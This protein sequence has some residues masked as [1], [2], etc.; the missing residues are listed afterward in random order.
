MVENEAK[1]K[2]KAEK[3]MAHIYE[4]SIAHFEEGQ[5]VKGKIV[6]LTPKEVIVDIGYKSEGI[7][8]MNEFR[9]PKDLKVGEEIDVL[10]EAKE[11]LTL[12]V[13]AGSIT[14][15]KDGKILIRGKDLV[16]RADR[17]NRIKGG[18][19]SIN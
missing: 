17:M 11:N 12:R 14:L 4:S 8:S 15:R 10:L 13:G 3:G 19:V 9:S 1:E 7:I 6:G 16:S 18:A 2:E 5:I